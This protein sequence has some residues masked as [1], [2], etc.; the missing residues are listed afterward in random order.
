MNVKLV[1]SYNGANYCGWQIQPNGVSV[2]GVVTDAIFKLTGKK[3]TLIGSG[4]TDAGVH[5]LGQIANFKIEGCSVPPEKFYKALN[6]LLPSD[7]RACESELADNDFNARKSAKN[8]TYRYSFYYSET[9]N[10]LIN[11]IALAL[12]KKPNFSLMRKCAEILKGKHDFKCFNASGSGAKTTVRE[13][14]EI[15]F[16]K[17]DFGFFVEVTGNGFLYN[18]VRTLAGTLLEVGYGIKTEEDVKNMLV[19]GNRSLCGKTLPAK[20]LTLLRA[21]Y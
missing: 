21:E 6:T 19:S 20:G 8:K 14:Y 9:E 3:V 5:A 18:M 12:Q 10:P 13:I 1:L 4:R 11:G 2:Q 7:I 16:I 15:D 17:K